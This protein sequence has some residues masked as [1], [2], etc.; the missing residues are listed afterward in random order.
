MKIGK[1]IVLM[2][3]A[4]LLLTVGAVAAYGTTFWAYSSKAISKTYKKIGE[5]STKDN[6]KKGS[7]N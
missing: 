6:I 4:I 1:K 5:D 2:V 3:M 7:Q